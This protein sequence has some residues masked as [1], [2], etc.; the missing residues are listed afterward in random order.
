V[1]EAKLSRAA[2]CF[3]RRRNAARRMNPGENMLWFAG[4]CGAMRGSGALRAAGARFG[5]V[6]WAELWTALVGGAWLCCAQQGVARLGS[7]ELGFA[8]LCSGRLCY[9]PIC[10]AMRCAAR[11]CCATQGLA[12]VSTAWLSN[13]PGC[14]DPRREAVR[15]WAKK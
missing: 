7:D 4:L 8:P 14:S 10:A 3:A 13:A 1:S 2:L 5:L 6:G 15:G 11:V 9:A 12:L